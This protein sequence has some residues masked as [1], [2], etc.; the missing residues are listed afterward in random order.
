M[1]KMNSVQADTVAK[2]AIAYIRVSTEEQVDGASLDQQKESIEKYAKENNITIVRWHG[3]PGR[4]AKNVTGRPGMLGLI[5]HCQK[6]G[7]GVIDYVIVYSTSRISRDAPTFYAQILIPLMKL[8]IEVRSV[9]EPAIDGSPAGNF[10]LGVSILNGQLDNQV[11]SKYV[12]DNMRAVIRQ[13]YWISNPP[14]GFVIERVPLEGSLVQGRRK[15]RCVLAPDTKDNLASNIASLF[16]RFAE[17][18]INEAELLRMAHKLNIRTKKGELLSFSSLDKMLRTPA[19]AGY[20]TSSLLEKGEMVKLKNN[21]LVSLDTFKRIQAILNSDRQNYVVSDNAL[22]PLRGY[23]VCAVC[24]KHMTASAPRS[25]SG[26][27]SPRYHCQTKGCPSIGI[28]VAHGAFNDYL[29]S[30]TPKPETLKM[31]RE[32]IRKTALRKFGNTKAELKAVKDEEDSVLSTKANAITMFVDGKLTPED[33]D[34]LFSNINAKLEDIRMRRMKLEK[35]LE[36]NDISLEYVFNFMSMPAKLWRDSDLEA[37]QAIQK[38]IFPEGFYIDPKT[39]KCGTSKIS[40]LYSVICNKKEPN[41]DSNSKMVDLLD[42]NW[43]DI[44]WDI[45]R[46][47]SATSIITLLVSSPYNSRTTK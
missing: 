40:P 28:G 20:N 42:T 18:D 45:H 1:S 5:D 7:K 46:I 10:M 3:D 43:N 35:V 38:I 19:Y 4:S 44:L 34:L 9:I 24:G 23:L 37:R 21:G 22:Y 41:T 6:M 26:R 36:Q 27:R 16:N 2:K 30:V 17:G 31:A 47:K 13:G 15:C 33:K 39:K 12:T 11:K 32:L 25:G 29:E 14:L 8:G